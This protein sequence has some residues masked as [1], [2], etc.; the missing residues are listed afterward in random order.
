MRKLLS[1]AALICAM[2]PIAA[3]AKANLCEGWFTYEELAQVVGPYT[4]TVGGALMRSEDGFVGFLNSS[5]SSEIQLTLG[6]LGAS[7]TDDS[8]VMNSEYGDVE[9]VPMREFDDERMKM[10]QDHIGKNVEGSFSTRFG[11]ALDQLPWFLSGDE[12]SSTDGYSII[13]SYELAMVEL[14]EDGAKFIGVLQW[15]SVDAGNDVS[16]IRLVTLV[17]RD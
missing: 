2:Q 7:G 14:S 10:L 16:Q 6:N 13:Y 1:A 17:P 4:L 8:F 11:C 15:T 9:L 5:S 12:T 3:F